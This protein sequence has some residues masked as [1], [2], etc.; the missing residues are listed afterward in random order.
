M[1]EAGLKGGSTYLL[2]PTFAQ[3]YLSIVCNASPWP[4]TD[5]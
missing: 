1:F 5:E 2:S 3:L 4:P